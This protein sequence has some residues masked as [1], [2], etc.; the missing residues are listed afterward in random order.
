[1]FLTVFIG[2]EVSHG[3]G[4][5]FDTVPEADREIIL[6]AFYGRL[7]V[8]NAALALTK[9]SI[10]WQYLLVFPGRK[11]RLA[12]WIMMGVCIAYGIWA[13][14]SNFFLCSPVPYFWDKTIKGRCL[15]E[16]A[17]WFTS[18]GINIVTDLII[19]A[20]PMPAVRQL[21]LPGR[22]KLALMGVFALGGM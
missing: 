4:R 3:E 6:K 22:S 20:L 10:L 7:A 18:A 21:Q 1:V 19:L 2:I 15:S 8:Y 13:L 9:V 17:N 5:H 16:Q 12:S 11:I 14:I